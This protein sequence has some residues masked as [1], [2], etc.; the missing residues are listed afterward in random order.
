MRFSKLL[1]NS[2]NRLINFIVITSLVIA[3]LYASYA[4]WDNSLIYAAADNVQEDML[5]LKPEVED[6]SPSFEDLLAINPDVKGW[7]ILDN[8]NIDHPILQGETN[9]SYINTDVYGDFSLAGSIFLDSRSN[10]DFKDNYSLLYGHHMDN[11]KMFGDLD[12]YK[13]GKFF[14][15]ND[16]GK[17]ILPNRIYNLKILACLVVPSSEESIFVPG[18]WQDGIDDLIQFAKENP[19]HIN[20]KNINEAIKSTNKSLKILALTTCSSEFTDARTVILTE[21]V[22]HNH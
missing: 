17:L 1:L 19:L 10:E 3:G 15:E 21:M 7:I 2:I 11:S 14:R 13:D 6:D 20:D 4:L 16:T 22:P 18:I 8:T 12:L 9:L 5:K